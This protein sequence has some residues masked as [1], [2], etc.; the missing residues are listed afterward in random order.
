MIAVL[1]VITAFAGLDLIQ[2]QSPPVEI[3][4]ESIN[5]RVD[6]PE[7]KGEILIF[8]VSVVLNQSAGDTV[9]VD[10]A[11]RSVQAKPG[12][13][14]NHTS[15]TLT[16][17]VGT[18]ERTF[19]VQILGDDLTEQ[20]NRFYID[21]TNPLGATISTQLAQVSISDNEPKALIWLEKIQPVKEGPGAAFNLVMRKDRAA[22][23]DH[24]L[25]VQTQP[26]EATPGSDYT[27][28]SQTIWIRA[29]MLQSEQITIQ[30][31]DDNEKE[32]PER[33]YVS[34]LYSGTEEYIQKRGDAEQFVWIIDDDI[35][36]GIHVTTSDIAHSVRKKH[37]QVAEG[38]NK[39]YRILLAQAPTEDVTIGTEL[40]GQDQD[41]TL[42]SPISHTFT[43]DNW[44]EPYWI[45]VEAAQ[46]DDTLDGYRRINHTIETTDPIYQD[47]HP[48]WVTAQ[49][50][51]D[52]LDDTGWEA[53]SDPVSGVVNG[54]TAE[55]EYTPKRH[56]W[57]PFL[58]RI[59]FSERITT[60]YRKMRD[61][62]LSVTDGEILRAYRTGG[63]SDDWTFEIGVHEGE[64]PMTITLQGGRA[65]NQQGAICAPGGKKLANTLTLTLQPPE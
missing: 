10:Y 43:P 59:K 48:R 9:T 27:S 44:F 45:T 17:P 54:I 49:E 63:K 18:T 22:E 13:D 60:S 32:L 58:I 51:D 46:D 62:A 64:Q 19:T 61:D 16:F 53:S 52:D 20:P 8:E 30:I 31:R 57:D 4:F 41:I 14:Y 47:H 35:R 15:G 2:A 50:M 40:W 29:Y 1:A 3:R 24:S 12:E 34:I 36:P 7:G 26:L 38:S 6:E 28:L 39:Q 11:T 55:F 56:D 23:F 21:L 37:L 5:M 25:T 65:C 42:D 33:V